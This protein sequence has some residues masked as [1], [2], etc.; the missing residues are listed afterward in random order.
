MQESAKPSFAVQERCLLPI[1][2]TS[3]DRLPHVFLQQFL[4]QKLGC[5]RGSKN[6]MNPSVEK[7]GIHIIR[8]I[9]TT[10]TG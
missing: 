2:P 10:S 3:V 8:Q 4:G 5:V 9:P 7:I 1:V 6:Q